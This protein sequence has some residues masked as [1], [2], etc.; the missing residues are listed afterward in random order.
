MPKACQK[1]PLKIEAL[2]SRLS[3]ICVSDAN[4]YLAGAKGTTFWYS[5]VQALIKSINFFFEFSKF[6]NF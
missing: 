2:K 5:K 6:L 1:I 4:K 3:N